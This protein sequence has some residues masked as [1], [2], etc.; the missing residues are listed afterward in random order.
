MF[1]IFFKSK[2]K[3]KNKHA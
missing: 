1:V 2:F 3:F